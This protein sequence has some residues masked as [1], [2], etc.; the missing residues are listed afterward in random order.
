MKYS[1]ILIFAAIFFLAWT[2]ISPKVNDSK[3]LDDIILTT[4][5]KISIGKDIIVKIENNSKSTLK[6]PSNCP[7]NP[8]LVERYLNGE[9]S[10]ITAETTKENCKNKEIIVDSGDKYSINYAP[11]NHDLF[12]KTGRYRV[13]LSTNLEGGEKLYTQEINITEANI[14]RLFWTKIFYKPIL[15]TLIF[16]ISTLSGNSLGWG[17]ILLTFLIKLILLIPNHRALR[18]QK[19]MRKVQPQLDA[20]KKKYKDNPQL[21]ASE[22]MKIWK[23]YKVNPMSSCLP[24]IIQ[25]P[26]LIALFYVVKGGL[27][28]INPNLL[29][30]SLKSFDPAII[31]P[32]FL[33]II[34]LT[35]V[36]TIVLPIIIGLLQFGQMKLTIGKNT[37]DQ[38]T[39]SPM[40]MMNK[41]M[42]YFM[43]IMIAVFTA[44]LPA[45][46][47]FYWGTSTLFGIG[48]QIFVNK[49]K[50]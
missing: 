7:K 12:T 47:G 33:G 15:N 16:L 37:K 20:L 22:T 8:L 25:F 43:P 23:K 31:N 50:D 17:I 32:I 21:L 19:M 41:S 44:G 29:Y 27:A 38:P 4:N 10:S 26:I 35:K 28:H 42:M 9:W 24:M 18:A 11:W 1:R 13:T 5:S 3:K 48:Q 40:P 49:S 34:D 46:V 39:N 2:F 45:A 6:I 14:I 30:A 36:N